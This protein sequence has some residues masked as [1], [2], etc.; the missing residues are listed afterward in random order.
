MPSVEW[1]DSL[2]MQSVNH[3]GQSEDTLKRAGLH[4]QPYLRAI[5]LT[6]IQVLC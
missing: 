2:T 6:E 3:R 1:M 5:L 4:L